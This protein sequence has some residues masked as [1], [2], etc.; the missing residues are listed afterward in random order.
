MNNLS[1][2]FIFFFE[3]VAFFMTV[4]FFIQF[5]ILK[6]KEYLFYAVYLLLLTVYYL[7]AIPEFFFGISYNDKI[8]IAE[9][10]LFKRPVQF[11]ISVFYSLFVMYYLGLKNRSRPLYLIFSYLLI[12]YLVFSLGCLAGNFFKIAY[13]PLY[14]SVGL[15]LFPLQL[16]VVTALFKYRVPYAHYIIWGSII[17]LVG[18]IVT[19]LL[20]MYMT[21]YPQGH[22]NNSNSYIPVMISILADIFLFTVAL[23]RKIADNE[24]ALINAAVSRH[25]AVMLERERIIADLHDDVGGGLSSIRMMSDLMAQDQKEPNTQSPVNFSKKISATAKEIALRMN[26]IIWSLNTENDTLQKFSEY[27]RHFGISFFEDSPIKFRFNLSGKLPVSKE[28]TGVQRKNLFLI[29]KEALHNSLKHS[30]AGEAMV[31]FQMHND[32][33][34]IEIADNGTGIL[35]PNSFGNGIKNMKKRVEEINATIHFSSGKGTQIQISLLLT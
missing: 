24:K 1:E 31:N 13:D 32:Q 26:T 14:Y 23:Q 9:F 28:L 21:K 27:V 12:L 16:Y 22:V 8:S 10:D 33:L 5:S 35:N 2:Y 34:L 19:L 30:G 4:F 20:S 3:S 17:V 29:I 11:L 18:S 25:Q 7:L 15:L 6:K